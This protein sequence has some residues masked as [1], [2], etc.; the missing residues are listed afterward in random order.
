MRLFGLDAVRKQ[1]KQRKETRLD[2]KVRAVAVHVMSHEDAD[3]GVGGRH[4]RLAIIHGA[5]YLCLAGVVEAESKV[6]LF[7]RF[8]AFVVAPL[9]VDL[10]QGSISIHESRSRCYPSQGWLTWP[11]AFTAQK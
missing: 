5:K 10:E 11:Q 8:L 2:G 1:G 4:V 7:A 6:V 9:A 3:P